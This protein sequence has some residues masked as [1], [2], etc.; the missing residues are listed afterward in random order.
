MLAGVCPWRWGVVD[1]RQGA[2]LAGLMGPLRTWPV[3][4]WTAPQRDWGVPGRAHP[5]YL[6][7]LASARYKM[8]F[9]CG[10]RTGREDTHASI[11]LVLS[12]ISSLAWQVLLGDIP[13]GL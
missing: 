2:T 13:V 8:D 3:D 4:S 12:R 6:E 1:Q 9:G 11:S 5:L 7:L 10:L